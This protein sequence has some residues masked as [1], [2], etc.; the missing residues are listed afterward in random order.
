MTLRDLHH[1]RGQSWQTK[2]RWAL[3]RDYDC[4]FNA[5][6]RDF[7]AWLERPWLPDRLKGPMQYP[8]HDNL[9]DSTIIGPQCFAAMT[10][11]D[12]VI[13]W[14]GVNY[15]RQEDVLHMTPETFYGLMYTAAGAA[16]R[17]LLED[18]PDYVF[19]STR[20]AEAVQYVIDT[21]TGVKPPHGYNAL[22]E[23]ESA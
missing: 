1:T 5:R 9:C 7:T 21:E 16:T 14:R 4:K 8:Y 3:L 10:D 19:P 22:R 13:N 11:H 6:A 15:I 20:V 17:P 12:T 18:H 23:D 2:L